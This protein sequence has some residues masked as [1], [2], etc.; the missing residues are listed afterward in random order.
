MIRTS[1]DPASYAVTIRS[2]AV[3]ALNGQSAS[4]FGQVLRTHS[5]A[6]DGPDINRGFSLSP[7]A[8][9][10][11][12]SLKSGEGYD[13]FVHDTGS[14]EEI[15]RLT[16][17]GASA[18]VLNL[19]PD[20]S[21]DG[22]LAAFSA[23]AN[24]EAGADLYVVRVDGADMAK[25]TSSPDS[26]E[27]RPSWSPD[28]TQLTFQRKENAANDPNWD[29]Y[30][31]D[32]Y[33]T[34][35]TAMPTP[36][37]AALPLSPTPGTTATPTPT[38][39]A[40]PVSPTPAATAKPPPTPTAPPVPPLPVADDHGNRHGD[41]TTLTVG[42][43]TP[44][45]LERAGDEDWFSFGAQA[46]WV[47]VVTA[48][49]DSLSD[50][51]LRL[52]GW[53]GAARII[54]DEDGGEAETARIE[55][56]APTGGTR[57]ISVSAGNGAT[58]GA[59]TLAISGRA[60]DHGSGAEAASTVSVGSTMPGEL[61]AAGDDD[62][63]ALAAQAGT[64]YRITTGL[65]T[66]ADSYLALSDSDGATR[67][68]LDDDGGEGQASR[69]A[70]VAPAS[71]TCYVNVR[72]PRSGLTGTYTLTIEVAGEAA[73]L[74]DH[75]NSPS[76]ATSVPVSTDFASSVSIDSVLVTGSVADE[77]WF[78]FAA[79]AG[80]V[81]RITADLGSLADSI[82]GLHDTDGVTRISFDGNPGPSSIDWVAPATATYYVRMRSNSLSEV[83]TY[84]LTITAEPDDHADNPAG[85]TEVPVKTDV[86][87]YVT[88]GGDIENVLGSGTGAAAGDEDWFSFQAEAGWVYRITADLGSL[89]DS[90]IGLHETGGVTRIRFDENLGPSH[91][92]WTAPA[93][94]TYFVR[95]RSRLQTQ[96]GTY[97]LTITGEPDD[98]ANNAIFATT[99]G[100]GSPVVGDI[101]VVKGSGEGA[102]AGDDD[103]FSFAA[104]AGT[105]YDIA[106]DLVSLAGSHVGLWDTDGLSRLEFNENSGP[107]R[108]E[109]WTAPNS[110]TYY[111]NVRSP[112]FDQAGG[113]T[114]TITGE[115]AAG[116]A[117]AA[118]P[119]AVKL[120]D[121]AESADRPSGIFGSNTVTATIPETRG[122]IVISA[123]RRSLV[124]AGIDDRMTLR[125][126]GP[127]GRTQEAFLY[128]NGGCNAPIG[129]Q[130]IASKVI[131]FEA[132]VNEIEVTLENVFAP[133][134]SNSGSPALY[135]IVLRPGAVEPEAPPWTS[136]C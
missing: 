48:A 132:G 4:E 116:P 9:F 39:A 86:A 136:T 61:E 83:G 10:F 104:L 117:A 7:D 119:L 90:N 110:G 73:T 59:Y 43:A 60:D 80:W 114:L 122:P 36:T 89:A 91:M 82:I 31:V 97:T 112:L 32:V 2:A 127:S 105:T 34:A 41:A 52:I 87:S 74:S 63:F 92:E 18:G 38:P 94:G 47:Y 118:L 35:A 75:G 123:A 13:L 69:I 81:Y 26:S 129:E 54:V 126:T 45:I 15:R 109:D 79:Q 102:A 14:G 93:T 135:L 134:G 71:G 100:D 30:V 5:A 85:A 78:S 55:W 6:T 99:V 68:R 25:V 44:G 111:V 115:F 77:D 124:P 128:D 121:A 131:E 76:N 17:T 19:Y 1:H 103:W 8:G 108:I 49:P 42:G 37:P 46:G 101:E 51:F 58:T 53:D 65:G 29:I 22:K 96:T 21:P 16:T 107:S 130:W 33:G 67:L 98:H 62:W 56:V 70:W 120:I 72:A 113:Y 84:T 12:I 57:Y 88:T 125:V 20:V 106:V 27:S 24:E 23:Q 11:V 3:A 64:A 133:P 50:P 40:L 95:M 28:G 66:L